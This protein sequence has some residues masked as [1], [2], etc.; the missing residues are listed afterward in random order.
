M[1][2]TAGK[3]PDS[4]HLL[5]LAQGLLHDVH[6]RLSHQA[7]V[8]VL[9][10]VK[11]PMMPALFIVERGIGQLPYRLANLGIAELFFCRERSPV[12]ARAIK[13]RMTGRCSVR[14]GPGR[15]SPIF[16]KKPFTRKNSSLCA[17]LKAISRNSVSKAQYG[18][19]MALKNVLVKQKCLSAFLA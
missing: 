7:G 17:L 1:R 16:V 3:M 10:M 2:E 15:T 9:G 19:A 11:A 13:A 5:R 18:R 8:D 4:F 14:K 12:S 6:F